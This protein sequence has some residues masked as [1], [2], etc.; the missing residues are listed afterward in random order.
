MVKRNMYVEG[1]GHE[2]SV[3]KKPLL[4]NAGVYFQAITLKIVSVYERNKIHDPLPRICHSLFILQTL[5]KRGIKSSYLWTH[6][7]LFFF[8]IR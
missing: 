5:S 3:H 4:L 2:T 6:S 8:H 1:K 7:N